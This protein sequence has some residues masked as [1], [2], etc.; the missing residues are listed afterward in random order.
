M[1]CKGTGL[2][3]V[4]PRRLSSFK[5]QKLLRTSRSLFRGWHEPAVGRQ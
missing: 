2:H 3:L 5:Q 1:C 4:G